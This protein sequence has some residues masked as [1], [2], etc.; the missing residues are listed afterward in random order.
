MAKHPKVKKLINV[1][2]RVYQVFV[3]GSH[4][5]FCAKFMKQAT[6]FKNGCNIDILCGKDIIMASY[7]YFMHHLLYQRSYLLATIHTPMWGSSIKTYRVRKLVAD[8]ESSQAWKDLYILLWAL[9]PCLP[10]LFLADVNR[11]GMRIFSLFWTGPMLQ[12]WGQT[13]ICMMMTSFLHLPGLS[14]DTARRSTSICMRKVNRRRRR[15]DEEE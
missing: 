6:T 1:A 3:S 13:V 5:S 12:L 4:H 15:G 8:I 10:V 14:M 11:P 9:F 7:L 2:K